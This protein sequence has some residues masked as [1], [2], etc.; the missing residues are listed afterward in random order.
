MNILRSALRN[1]LR[2]HE[3]YISI[4]RIL[5]YFE[6]FQE[7]EK[8]GKNGKKCFF[9]FFIELEKMHFLRKN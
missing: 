5:Y 3:E 9:G 7:L 4:E 2:I 1:I 6:C 8:T